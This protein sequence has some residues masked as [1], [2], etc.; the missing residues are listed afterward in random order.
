MT[1][2]EARSYARRPE[3]GGFFATSAASSIRAREFES[4]LLQ[5]G[6]ETE[7]SQAQTGALGERPGMQA[8]P[9]VPHAGGTKGP[10]PLCSSSESRAN[11]KTT[12]TFRCR[13][14]R[15]E[16]V[17]IASYPSDYPRHQRPSF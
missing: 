2:A 9:T 5:R 16:L 11:L 10:N 6:A 15:P 7:V 1:S 13:V 4:P 8:I 3:S 14:A 17:Y 12:S